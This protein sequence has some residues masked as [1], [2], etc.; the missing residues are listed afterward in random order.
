MEGQKE[1]QFYVRSPKY[2][3]SF[4]RRVIEEYLS[5]GIDKLTLQK[6]YGIR[7]K[8]AICTWMKR[9]EYED[10]RGKK[11]YFEIVNRIALKKQYSDKEGQAPQDEAALKARIKLLE[12]QLEDEKF[13]S[14]GYSMMIDIAEKELKVSIRKKAV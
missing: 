14:E 7:F 11:P 5:T 6:K 2:P 8:S 1:R 13:R 12:R 10:I 9:M 3:E 4:K